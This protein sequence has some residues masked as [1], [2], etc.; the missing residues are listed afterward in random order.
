CF[1]ILTINEF[2]FV[3]FAAY[4]LG[5]MSTGVFSTV[6][7]VTFEDYLKCTALLP[8]VIESTDNTGSRYV[9]IG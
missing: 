3:F 7:I 6:K 5:T 2:P 8:E 4:I 9:N 1:I